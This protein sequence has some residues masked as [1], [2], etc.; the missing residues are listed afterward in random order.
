MGSGT[1]VAKEAGDIVIVDDNFKSI[2]SAIL[3]GRTIYHNILKFCKFQLSINVGAVLVSAL[4]PFFGVDEPLTVIHLLFVNL[5]MDSLGS[6]ML[7]NEPA[8]DKYMKE[9]PR[10]RDE[11]IVSIDMLLQFVIIGVYMLS[12]GLSWFVSKYSVAY[13]FQDMDQAKTGFFAA[14][15]FAAILN[16]WNVRSEG[17]D[18]FNRIK[19]NM[20]F[21]KVMLAMLCTTIL[22]C[23]IGG[24]IG[25]VF[26]CY[27]FPLGYWFFVIVAGVL[28]IPVD[29]IRKLLFGTYKESNGK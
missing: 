2:R 13:F 24:P 8:L 1:A 10:R 22:L 5:C 9:P 28:V 19:D 25:E 18:I 23:A 7:G 16:G 26:S 3:Y 20:N 21:V 4:L 15:M 14:F 29:M 27:R 11:S 17:F 6:L 12:I